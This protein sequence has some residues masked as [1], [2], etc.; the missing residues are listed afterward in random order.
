MIRSVP[1]IWRRAAERS[2]ALLLAVLVLAA[3]AAAGTIWDRVSE[4]TL[5]NG[6][7][8]LLVEEPK[9]PV[10]S[11]QIWYKVGSRNEPAGKG[12]LSHMLEHMMFKGT[13]RTGPKQFSAIVQRNGGVDNAHTGSDATAYYINFA[14]DR[15]SLAL[16]LEADRMVNL[17]F[18]EKEFLPERDVVVEERRLRIEDQPANALGELLMA[19]AFLAHPY[20]RPIIGW[21]SEI[22]GYTLQDLIQHYRTYYAPSNATLVVAGDFAKIDLLTKIQE[23]FGAILRGPSPPPQVIPQEPPQQGERRVFLR[24]EAELPVFYA[25]HHAPN[26]SH[27]DSYPLQV[28]AYILG[29]GESAR[30]HR[31]VVYEKQLA[32]YAGADYD[33]A[34]I[35]P[36]LFSVSAGP[37]PGKTAEEVER[38][39]VA[40]LDRIQR[41]PVTDRELVKAKNQIE[42][43][44]VFAQDSVHTL[45]SLLGHYESV[46]SWKLLAGYVDGIRKVTAADV[47]RVAR[48]YLILDNRSVAILVPSR[49]DEAAPTK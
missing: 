2:V 43:E 36:F 45:A 1:P 8:V 41:E 47:Q 15:V 37:L 46:G 7:K 38:A 16:E 17:L 24:K 34:H 14:A 6:L 42:A 11:V 44:F 9:S 39:V 40:E 48:T 26:L 3:P 5:A 4:T 35:D 22:K 21:P 12:G 20:G 31:N 27:P 19:S 23:L 25:A 28:L 13:P 10:V 29:G 30:L 18:E 49:P 32:A 33:P